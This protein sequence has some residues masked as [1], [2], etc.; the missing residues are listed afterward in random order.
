MDAKKKLV[1]LANDVLQY[2]PYGEIQIDTAEQI[3]DR[4]IDH[5]VT[6][7]DG[8]TLEAFLHPID[9]YKG[10]KA[11]YL[12]FKA[13]TGEMVE[14]CF[15]LRPDKDPAAVEALRAYANVTDNE[16]LAEDIYNWVGDGL[17]AQKCAMPLE[18]WHEDYGDVLWWKFPIEE[19][20][21]VGSPLDERWPGYHTH[22]TPIVVPYSPKGE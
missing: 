5:G 10:L 13:D 7:Q 3:A 9:A 8:K 22:W 15:V 4:M 16:T 18:E 6:V 12:V 1:E 14:N 19:P 20:P 17:T 2:L 11:K 21:Y